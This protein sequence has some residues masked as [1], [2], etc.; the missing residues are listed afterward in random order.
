MIKKPTASCGPRGI[1]GECA[2]IGFDQCRGVGGH[3]KAAGVR[4]VI[5]IQKEVVFVLSTR[6]A[7]E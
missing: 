4:S 6:D 7:V 3:G 5:S 1:G 2:S